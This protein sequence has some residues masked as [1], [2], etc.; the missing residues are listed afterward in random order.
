MKP[1]RPWSSLFRALLAG[2]WLWPFAAASQPALTDAANP[3]QLTADE[4][5]WIAAHPRI[6]VGQETDAPPLL[7]VGDDGRLSGF[8]VD[9]I[10]LLNQYLGTDIVIETGHWGDILERTK[11]GKID[12]I[13]ATFAVDRLRKHFNFTQPLFKPT[14]RMIS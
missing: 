8:I 14:F 9:Y 7:M 10:A 1:L 4:R 3:V 2:F 5:A 13:G 11:A 6:I 12:M